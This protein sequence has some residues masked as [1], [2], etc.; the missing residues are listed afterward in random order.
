MCIEPLYKVPHAYI[1]ILACYGR[2]VIIYKL[3][4]LCLRNFN[5]LLATKWFV[6][7]LICLS[8]LE[9]HSIALS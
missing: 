1:Y 9:Y 6:T 8:V 2:F 7:G 5:L 4:V 3:I